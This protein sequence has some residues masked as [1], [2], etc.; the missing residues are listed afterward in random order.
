M[1]ESKKDPLKQ[2]QDISISFRIHCW[3]AVL[4]PQPIAD[5]FIFKHPAS[6]IN[7]VLN[8]NKQKVLLASLKMYPSVNK[9]KQQP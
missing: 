4:N 6:Y 1:L 8:K 7:V 5:L 2:I 9:S 3:L